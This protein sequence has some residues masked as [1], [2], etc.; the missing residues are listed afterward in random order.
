MFSRSYRDEETWSTKCGNR[1]LIAWLVQ[2]LQLCWLATNGTQVTTLIA[3]LV[4]ECFRERPA[5]SVVGI[6]ETWRTLSGSEGQRLESHAKILM[7]RASSRNQLHPPHI[8]GGLGGGGCFFASFFAPKKV[9]NCRAQSLRFG[10]A[11]K[12]ERGDGGLATLL[13]ILSGDRK[14]MNKKGGLQDIALQQ[15]EFWRNSRRILEEFSSNCGRI[16]WFFEQELN[17]INL[18]SLLLIRNPFFQDL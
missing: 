7:E 1:S 12:P 3:W 11:S 9:R 6:K 18:L 2:A 4:H 8:G 17:Q 10:K 5:F 13:Q 15:L 14:K 16:R